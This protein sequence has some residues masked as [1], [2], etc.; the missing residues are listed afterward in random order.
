MFLPFA[1]GPPKL[2]KSPSSCDL[3]VQNVL[4]IMTVSVDLLP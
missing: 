4:F 1:P 2:S 3:S